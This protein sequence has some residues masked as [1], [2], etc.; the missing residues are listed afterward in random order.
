MPKN[1]DIQNTMP[2]AAQ[3]FVSLLLFLTFSS[4][5]AADT[6]SYTSDS[7][8]IGDDLVKSWCLKIVSALMSALWQALNFIQTHSL[9][10][11]LFLI[12]FILAV[13]QGLRTAIL[14]VSHTLLE[15][16]HL[17]LNNWLDQN[18]TIRAL[19]QELN[20]QYDPTHVK[21]L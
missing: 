11:W 1:L 10:P 17:V 5:I 15:G 13:S 20:A 16:F 6:V 12:G 14:D 19:K 9:P 18:D 8:A 7:I 4:L 2:T 3:L 21:R